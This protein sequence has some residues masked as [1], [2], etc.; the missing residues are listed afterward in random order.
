MEF[1]VIVLIIVVVGLALADY[2]AGGG[3][4]EVVLNGKKYKI[5]KDQGNPQSAAPTE[6][7]AFLEK[8]E[9][10]T[11]TFLQDGLRASPGDAR[12][13]RI[14]K[15]WDGRLKET[16]F[17]S[18]DIAFSVKKEAVYVCVRDKEGKLVDPTVAFF[19]LLHEF[20]HVAC[21]EIGHTESFWR[22][23]RWLLEL[24]ETTGH[25]E[26]NHHEETPQLYCGRHI[27]SSPLTCVKKGSCSP[28]I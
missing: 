28:L 24:A 14:Q 7:A 12:L 17:H 6:V 20:A 4:I 15:R 21:P 2:L 16:T 5:R 25:Y 26:W 23:F 22:I 27:Y 10:K 3:H 1:I 8:L 13:L 9:N 18:K 19:V 11:K